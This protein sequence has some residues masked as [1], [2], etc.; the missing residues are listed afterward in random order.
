M[1]KI[2]GLACPISNE[3]R[4]IGKTSRELERRLYAHI[5]E[6]RR[7]RHS[8]KHRWI[9]KC[10]DRG[11]RPTIWLLEE[12]PDGVSWQAREKAW[13][14]RA[15][16]MEFELTNQTAGGEGLEFLD[17]IAKAA[18]KKKLSAATK[19][20]LQ[21]NPALKFALIEGTKRS[22]SENKPKRLAALMS[23]WNEENRAKHREIMSVIS[24]T[25]EFKKAKSDG[26]KKA[27]ERDRSVFMDAFA[28]PE[29]KA[30]QSASKRASW[31]DPEVRARMMNR[32]TPEARAKQAQEI[33]SRKDKIQAAMTPEV[34]AKQ[35][36][37]LKE[38]WAKRKS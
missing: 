8:H 18:Y 35:A 6:S 24:K 26:Q 17:P 27:W 4:Y 23:G 7:T 10:L 32:W 2:Y 12:V 11:L 21:R 13:I 37:K 5:S 16:E 20:S 36:A 33:L 34:R 14:K 22:W 1:V 38:T 31:S 3:I 9:A 28:A 29:V 30:K 15:L 25:P 19:K